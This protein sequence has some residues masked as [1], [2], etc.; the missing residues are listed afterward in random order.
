MTA[1]L[2]LPDPLAAATQLEATIALAEWQ[3]HRDRPP[4]RRLAEY[5][6]VVADRAFEVQLDIVAAAMRAER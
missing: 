4:G 6:E 3:R 5:D 1:S 2:Y